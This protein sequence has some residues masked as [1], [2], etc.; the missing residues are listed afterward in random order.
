MIDQVGERILSRVRRLQQQGMNGSS[1]VISDLF[2]STRGE[3]LF[4]T[5]SLHLP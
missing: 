4:L 3:E 5:P 1:C 2:L